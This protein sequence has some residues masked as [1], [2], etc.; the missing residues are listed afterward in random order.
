MGKDPERRD[1]KFQVS[2]QGYVFKNETRKKVEVQEMY[3]CPLVL[4]VYILLQLKAP[5]S[6]ALA[7]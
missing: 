2:K 3:F 4:K 7:T 1:I 6:T 5:R